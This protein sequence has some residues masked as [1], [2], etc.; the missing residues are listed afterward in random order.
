MGKV[1]P[2]HPPEVREEA[3]RLVREGGMSFSEAAAVVGCSGQTVS[4][5]VAQA[6]R[7]AGRRTDGLTTDEKAELAQLRRRVRVLEQEEE[8][9]KKAAA[10]VAKETH[11]TPLTPS[12]SSRRSG[13]AVAIMCQTLG[14]SRSA[15]PA[16]ATTDGWTGH[17][18]FV[19][20]TTRCVDRR[21]RGRR[22]TLLEH[23]DGSSFSF[24]PRRLATSSLSLS[25]RAL[26]DQPPASSQARS[27]GRTAPLSRSTDSWCRPGRSTC[28]CPCLSRWHYPHCGRASPP[29]IR[30]WL[31][32][33]LLAHMTATSA[34]RGWS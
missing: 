34:W 31:R 10:G 15:G 7:D 5:W 6:D 1:P 16:R 9:L 17:H 26:S 14:R 30:P 11:S 23:L 21:D 25:S 3:V 24:C 20:S 8:I 33:R 27:C 22:E 32:L 28:P 13:L 4:N 2:P 12:S 18:H 29:S 19:R